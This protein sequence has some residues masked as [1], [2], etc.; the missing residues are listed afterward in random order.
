MPEE[1]CEA[2]SK[3]KKKKISKE[4]KFHAFTNPELIDEPVCFHI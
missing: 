1:S 3:T 4:D 2:I